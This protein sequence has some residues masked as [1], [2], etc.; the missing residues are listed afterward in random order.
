MTTLS[1]ADL[2][3]VRD[4]IGTVTPPT[5]AQLRSWR[6]EL[7]HRTLVAIRALKRRRA[8]VAGGSTVDSFSLAGV[9]SVSQRANIKGLDDQ[10]ARLQAEYEAETGTDLPGGASSTRLRRTT[11]R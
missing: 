7:G 5:D 2:A 3:W 9:F 11:A 4:E 1:P 6:T 8:A 10:I